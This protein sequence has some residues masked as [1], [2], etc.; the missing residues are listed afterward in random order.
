MPT[1]AFASPLPIDSATCMPV[2]PGAYSRTEPS[3]RVSWILVAVDMTCWWQSPWTAGR[4][5]IAMRP[6]GSKIVGGRDDG[7]A[8]Q[9]ATPDPE[10]AARAMRRL[11]T[12][13]LALAISILGAATATAQCNL[14][15]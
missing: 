14:V 5:I 8:P 12:S 6:A 15:P 4:R 11:A 3:G 13:S 9:H 7:P 1:A 10:Y 2:V